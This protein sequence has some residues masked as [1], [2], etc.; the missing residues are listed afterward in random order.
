[1]QQ[2]Q[3]LT[4]ALN[5]LEAIRIQL[6]EGRGHERAVRFYQL[7]QLYKLGQRRLG[8]DMAEHIADVIELDNGWCL[9]D[10]R[11]DPHTWGL[12]PN[13]TA[14][15][16][17]LCGDGTRLLSLSDFSAFEKASVVTRGGRR[18]AVGPLTNNEREILELIGHGL[19]NGEIA[20]RLQVAESSIKNRITVIFRKLSVHSRTEAALVARDLAPHMPEDVA[21]DAP[22]PAPAARWRPPRIGKLPNRPGHKGEGSWL[23]EHR[24]P[25][26]KE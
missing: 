1:M 7:E 17:A 15:R 6:R 5:E 19:A 8:D 25:Q 20:Q 22:A 10:W 18:L 21:V 24:P 12:F 13:V 9:V 11:T 3:T 4:N 16:S 2:W 14:M 23:N 26:E